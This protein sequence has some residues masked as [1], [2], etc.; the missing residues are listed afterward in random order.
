MKN[1]YTKTEFRLAI[2][3]ACLLS[4]LATHY[5]QDTYVVTAFYDGVMVNE[6][7]TKWFWE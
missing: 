1:K 3:V 5:L 6:V 7:G 2:A 4:Y